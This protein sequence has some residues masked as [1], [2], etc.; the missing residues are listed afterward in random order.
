MSIIKSIIQNIFSVQ[1][2][3]NNHKVIKIFCFKIKF[4]TKNNIQTYT[5]FKYIELNKSYYKV[6]EHWIWDNNTNILNEWEPE[7]YNT[8]KYFLDPSTTYVDIGAWVGLTIFMAANIGVKDIY[9]VEANPLSYDLVT[10]NCKLNK[11]T[12]TVKLDNICITDKD[13]IT[14]GFGG[15]NDEK[16]TS[17]ASNIRGNC[18]QIPSKKLITYLN[19]YNLLSSENLFIKI[20]I[21]GAE[22]LLLDD[23]KELVAKD[24]ITIYLSLHPPFMNNKEEFCNKLISFCYDF[25]QVLDSNLNFLP[26]ENLIE[27]ILT[28]EKYPSW[29]TKFGNF[30]EIT[31]TNKII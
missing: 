21:E 29:G 5:P 9:A 1:N 17:S 10:E 18:W 23:I 3:N 15:R 30:F 14:V 4:K 24:N 11:I 16:N 13:N 28:E 12:E 7:T 19:N 27:M 22:E 26:K 31:L 2:D 20:D 6:K 8:Y 25:K